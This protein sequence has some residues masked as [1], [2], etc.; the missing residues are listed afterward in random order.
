MSDFPTSAEEAAAFD[1]ADPLASRRALFEMPEGLTYLVGHSLGPAT[2]TAIA[3]VEEAA[4]QEWAGGLVAS[5]N[6]AGWIDLAKKV[7]GR[8][9]PLIGAAPENVLIADSVSVNLFKLAGAALPHVRTKTIMV[10]D[11]EFPTDQYIAEGLSGLS[12]AVFDRLK[13]GTAFDA[14]AKGGVLI[15]SLVGY[16]SGL[17]ADVAAY[18]AEAEK[19]GAMI[20]WDL[21][22]AVGIVPVALEADG[23]KLAAGCTYKYL[24][25][26]PGAPAFLYAAPGIVE[27]LQNPMPGWLGHVKPFA[28]DPN[29]Q[30]A[31]G[32]ERFTVGTPSILS[33]SA[34]DGALAAFESVTPAD[35][36]AKAGTMGDMVL[37]RIEGLAKYGVS[38]ASPR[39]RAE[40]G[41]HVSFTHAQGFAV[42]KALAA[43]SIE[44]DFREPTTIRFGLSPLFLSYAQLWAAMDVLEDI[45]VTGSW[46]RPAFKVRSKVT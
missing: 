6:K 38:G 37:S 17:I 16:R 24:N 35:L 13:A 26:G 28:F 11:D 39:D 46:D 20:V 3:R 29:Y 2:R 9:A 21:S 19:H 15:K 1:A 22:H 10:E 44:S 31:E 14:L 40:R 25:G 8:L 23:A 5:W 41:G 33:L 42:V 18:E 45:L 27:K 12:G 4:R 32:V 30:P 34:L 43:H 7:G 36:H